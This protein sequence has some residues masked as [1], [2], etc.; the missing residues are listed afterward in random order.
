MAALQHSMGQLDEARRI[1]DELLDADP[2]LLPALIERGKVELDAQQPQQAEQWLRRAEAL[3]PHN[4][5]VLLALSRTLR[6]TGNTAEAQKYQERYR[7]VEALL[8]QH[9]DSVIDNLRKSIGSR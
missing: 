9:A 3:A 2:K 1:L 6:L 8:R 4:M 7:E 5:D